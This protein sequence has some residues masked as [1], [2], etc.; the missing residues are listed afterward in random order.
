MSIKVPKALLVVPADLCGELEIE[1][2]LQS[3]TVRLELAVDI[4]QKCHGRAAKLRF[5]C[6]SRKSAH[7]ALRE[8]DPINPPSLELWGWPLSQH[9]TVCSHV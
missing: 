5:I 1:G 3:P 2:F 6:E 4:N 8:V 7:S 9:L